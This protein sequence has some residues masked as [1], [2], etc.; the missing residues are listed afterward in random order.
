M[1]KAKLEDFLQDSVTFF[2]R[3]WD[4][5]PDVLEYNQNWE[6]DSPRYQLI[7]GEP[8]RVNPILNNLVYNIDLQKLPI[9]KLFKSISDFGIRLIIHNTPLGLICYYE[10]PNVFAGVQ[11]P[12]HFIM[13]VYDLRLTNYG[14]I[15]HVAFTDVFALAHILGNQYNS[16]PNW[17]T[18][19]PFERDL[20]LGER[21]Q[22][23]LDR[24]KN[25]K[26]F[27]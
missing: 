20:L 7:G 9:D 11:T 10:Y 24:H 17:A 5:I 23:V 14:F 21:I 13:P 15:A 18:T 4:E 19:R 12:K 25:P 27:R 8:N 3:R 6:K 26:K 16:P 1:E 2:H 22:L